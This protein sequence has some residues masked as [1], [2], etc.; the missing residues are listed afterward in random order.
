MKKAVKEIA[1]V[2]TTEELQKIFESLDTGYNKKYILKEAYKEG[3]NHEDKGKFTVM[4]DSNYYKAMTMLEFNHGVLLSNAVTD[5]H[6]SFALEFFQSLLKEFD[7]KTPS[8]KSL[9]ETV[10]LNFVRVLQ[11]QMQIKHVQKSINTRYDIQH[12]AVLSKELDRAERHYLTS[13]QT[14]RMYKMPQLAVNINTQ[15]AFVGNN[16]VLQKNEIN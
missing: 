13:L 6:S 1:K 15:N 7:C 9:A 4:P 2:K 11:N 3:F 14:L 8:E 12:L 5:L 10:A 16:Q